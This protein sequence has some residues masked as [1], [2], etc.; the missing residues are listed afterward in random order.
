MTVL[1]VTPAQVLA[2]KLSI[3]LDEE[4]GRVPDPAVVAIANAVEMD[5]GPDDF[6]TIVVCLACRVGDH[7]TCY[8][9]LCECYC[10][11]EQV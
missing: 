6:D 2:A 10:A 8:G 4:D 9:E 5:Y 3:M 7:Q 11:G 1:R